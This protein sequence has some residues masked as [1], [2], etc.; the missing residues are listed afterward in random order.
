MAD[1]PVGC[2]RCLTALPDAL[3]ALSEGDR[4]P[5]CRY[6]PAATRPGRAVV[7]LGE[8][9]LER[10]LDLPPHMHITGLTTDFTRLGI[11]LAVESGRLPPRAS[12]TQ[13]PELPL[14]PGILDVDA[15]ITR[16]LGTLADLRDETA[17][18]RRQL[19]TAHT[20]DAGRH[21][22]G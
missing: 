6:D 18:L 22:D 3:H 8:D 19:G 4:C 1:R 12:G 7:F 14:P 13:A 21:E 11:L 10:L 9:T 20:D 16:L 15:K 17:G 5:V 2:P